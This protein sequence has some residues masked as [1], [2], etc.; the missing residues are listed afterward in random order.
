MITRVSA[1]IQTNNTCSWSVEAPASGAPLLSL[2]WHSCLCTVRKPLG[3]LNEYNVSVSGFFSI[4]TPGF[5]V[6]VYGSVKTCTEKNKNKSSCFSLTQG[7]TFTLFIVRSS[8]KRDASSFSLE[9]KV[10]SCAVNSSIRLLSDPLCTLT[11]SWLS[12]GTNRHQAKAE[13]FRD[14][15]PLCVFGLWEGTRSHDF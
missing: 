11:V 9:D 2:V 4:C 10:K 3:S 8:E 13:T 6:C 14:S 12:D 5:W 1:G 15:N 7:S